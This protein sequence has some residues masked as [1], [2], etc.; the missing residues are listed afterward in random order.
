MGL[1]FIQGKWQAHLDKYLKLML[2]EMVGWNP[3]LRKRQASGSLVSKPI[4]HSQSLKKWVPDKEETECNARCI[5]PA[6]EGGRQGSRF[7]NKTWVKKDF[8]SF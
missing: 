6:T 2:V 8:L 1:K 4:H 3:G 7:L 5:R